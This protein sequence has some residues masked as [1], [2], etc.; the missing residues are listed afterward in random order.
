MARIDLDEV[1]DT[2]FSLICPPSSTILFSHIHGL[3]W[4]MLKSAP[5]FATLWPEI[6]SFWANADFLLAHNASF[7]R[8]VL[9][10]CCHHIGV[11]IP[12]QA[13]LCTLKGS[14]SALALSSHSLPTVC[15]HFGIPL[16][17]H[18]AASDALACAQ[19]YLQLRKSGLALERFQLASLSKHKTNF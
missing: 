8:R 18:N 4:A 6:S 14:R 12:R 13:F 5:S 3:T 11:D 10:G 9:Y 15:S 16:Q 1:L 2:F 17:H 19:I 7:D